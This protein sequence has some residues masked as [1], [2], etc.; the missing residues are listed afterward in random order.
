MKPK[1][2]IAHLFLFICI[3]FS[4]CLKKGEDDPL[5]SL[6]TR[7]ARLT[8]EWTMTSGKRIDYSPGST[9]LDLTYTKNSYTLIETDIDGSTHE[10]SGSA[11]FTII[12][13]KDGTFIERQQLFINPTITTLTGTWN[14]TGSVGKAKNK[15]RVTLHF[16]D[17]G[18]DADQTYLLKELRN[19]RLVIHREFGFPNAHYRTDEFAFEQ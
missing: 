11:L 6:R 7:K 5:I 14:F 1:I 10:S 16:D 15:D 18:V 9:S 4:S 12:F 19:K 2:L 3:S 13:K 8:G 17:L